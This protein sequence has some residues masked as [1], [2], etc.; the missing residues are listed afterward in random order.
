MHGS[1]TKLE[2]ARN[3]KL[4]GAVNGNADFDGSKNITI[5]TVQGNIVVLIGTMT[6][7][8]NSTGDKTINYPKGYSI[9]NS[10]LI[11]CGIKATEAKGYNYEGHFDDSADVLNSSYKR[12]VNLNSSNIVLAVIN[13]MTDQSINVTYKIVLMKVS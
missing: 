13:P 5:N 12:R 8:K 3:I 6:V 2:T 9:D 1:A 7:A 4:Q 10:V 11:S